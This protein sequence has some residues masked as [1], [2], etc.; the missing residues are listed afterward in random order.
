MGALVPIPKAFVRCAHNIFFFFIAHP[1][2][3][4]SLI[5]KKKPCILCKA[6]GMWAI[7]DLNQ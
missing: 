1:C 5:K 7:L 4:G 3:P 2:K 6:L